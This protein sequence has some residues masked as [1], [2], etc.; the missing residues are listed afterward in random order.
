MSIVVHHLEY[1]RSTRVL[2]LLEELGID[3]E[4]KRYQRDPVTSRSPAALGEAHPLAKAP[5]VEVDGHAMVE[6]GAILEYLIEA[7]GDGRMSVPAGSPDRAAY[8]EWLHFAEGTMAMPVILT[9]LG[10]RFGGLG[11]ILGGFLG[12]EVNKLLDYADTHMQS[13]SFVV[14]DAMTGADINLAYLLEVSNAG[15]LLESRPTL[16][17]YLDTLMA[18]P[19]YK[20]AIELGGPV[21][22]AGM[23]KR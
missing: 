17:A 8:L 13:R 20:K 3:Y 9:L 22:M 4:M 2:W 18:R 12:G 19:A 1:S 11:D 23:G 10:P 7:H 16:K 15:G 21:V 14:G 6:S 5:T